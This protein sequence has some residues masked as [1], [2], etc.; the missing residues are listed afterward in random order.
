[1]TSLH[2]SNF[3]LLG[4][5]LMSIMN[6]VSLH[7][8]HLVRYLYSSYFSRKNNNLVLECSSFLYLFPSLLFVFLTSA[9][10]D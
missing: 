4:T 8:M 10:F 9:F 5:N 1:M 3:G 6:L 7:R 2:F